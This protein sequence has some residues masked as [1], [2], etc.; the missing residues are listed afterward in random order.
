MQQRKKTN[1]KPQTPQQPVVMD[2]SL[3]KELF[4]GEQII[5]HFKDIV[6]PRYLAFIASVLQIVDAN[7]DLWRAEPQSLLKAAEM[8]AILDLP[9][10]NNLRYAHISAY[11]DEK[12]GVIYAQFNVDWRGLLQLGLRSG[13]FKTI[14]VS[15][16]MEGELVNRDRLSGDCTFNWE[17]DEEKRKVLQPIGYVSYFKLLS[18]FEKSVYRTIAELDAHGQKY[19]KTFNT[20]GSGWDLERPAMYRKTVLK[21]LLNNYAP[22]T[23]ETMLP[24][25]AAIQ[26]D[27]SVIMDNGK[28]EYPDNPTGNIGDPVKV[29]TKERANKAANAAE[30]LL[31]QKGG[32]KR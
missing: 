30:E 24:I 15:D 23:V 5:N 3:I 6:G 20:K 21:E 2:A 17:Q 16:V 29:D 28:F 32:K 18:G 27:Q 19:S 25:A 8:A 13:Q 11:P 4:K 31:L 10:N 26:A 1:Q 12:T 22:M 9:L 7:R 14:N